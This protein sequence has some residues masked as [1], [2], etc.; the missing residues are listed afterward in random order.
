MRAAI[1]T[2]HLSIRY[3][4]LCRRSRP[5]HAARQPALQFGASPRA[6]NM[7]AI[8]A[9][10]FAALQGRDYV[11]PDDVKTLAPPALRH[12][13]VL[14]PGS[15]IEGLDADKVVGQILDQVPAPR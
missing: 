1:E 13:L 11:I 2:I 8:A 5:R 9:R 12:R 4:R 6:G 14:A 3:R 7:L 10:A 15:E